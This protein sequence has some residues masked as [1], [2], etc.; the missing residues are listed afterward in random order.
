MNPRARLPRLLIGITLVAAIGLLVESQVRTA[1]GQSPAAPKRI[2][3]TPGPGSPDM[4]ELFVRGAPWPVARAHVSVLK[5]YQGHVLDPTPSYFLPND[6]HGLLGVGA[7]RTVTRLWHKQIGLEVGVVK[8]QYCSADGSAEE[9]AIRDTIKS[10]WD[11]EAAGGHVNYLAMDEPFIS[12]ATV[13]QCGAPD[14]APAADRVAHYI[15]TV[16]K[17]DPGVEIGLIEPYPFFSAVRIGEILDLLHSRGIVLPFFHLDAGVDVMTP[18]ARAQVPNDLRY[19]AGFCAALGT[20][21]G[22]I[23]NGDNGDSAAL[24][25]NGVGLRLQLTMEA[26]GS[27]ADM[28]DDLIFQ[29]W[30][31][32]STGQK[33]VPPNLPETT[34]DTHTNLIVR[35]LLFLHGLGP[36]I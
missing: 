29:S 1:T 23:F 22:M 5:F 10:I 6:Y 4:R 2:W 33:I 25:A 28:P 36:G 30:A 11:V 15:E 14:L 21:F 24:Y 27:W 17:A 7:F 32:S 31:Q 3:F 13:P 8:S 19:L 26:F 18:A 35:G 20:R 12:G 16:K 34:P 9:N